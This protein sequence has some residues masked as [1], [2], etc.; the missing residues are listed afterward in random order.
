MVSF[1]VVSSFPS[2]NLP[3]VR[4]KNHFAISLSIL[5]NIPTSFGVLPKA[6]SSPKYLKEKSFQHPLMSFPKHFHPLAFE[7]E[8]FKDFSNI[9]QHVF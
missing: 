1:L 8:L 5:F 9:P 3:N 2:H 4:G 6:P 7:K